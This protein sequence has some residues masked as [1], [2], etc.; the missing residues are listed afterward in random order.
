[1]HH[2]PE[3]LAP[4]GDTDA[5]LAAIAAGAD[6]IFLGLKHFSARMKAENFSIISLANIIALAH[7]HQCKVYVAFNTLIKPSDIPSVLHMLSRIRHAAHPDALIIQD[8]GLIPIIQDMHFPGEIHLSTL[9]NVTHTTSLEEARHI[10][11]HRVVLPR[12]ILLSEL[13]AINTTCPKGLHL[14]IFVHGALCY[15]VS[16]RCYWSSYLGGKSGLRGRCVQPCRRVYSQGKNSARFFSSLDLSLESLVQTLLPLTAIKSWKIEGRKKSPHYV[17][18]T[19][20]AYRIL[21]DNPNDAT[22]VAEAKKLL[23]YAISRTTIALPKQ[24]KEITPV[25]LTLRTNT[26]ICVGEVLAQQSL[27]DK[28]FSEEQ[29]AVLISYLQQNA[30]SA[31]I[32]KKQRLET[33]Q[34]YLLQVFSESKQLPSKHTQKSTHPKKTQSTATIPHILLLE[35]P[36]FPGDKIRIGYEDEA[37]HCSVRINKHYAQ[38]SAFLLHL[39][40]Q[41]PAKASVFAYLIDR[42][43]AIPK[44]I[45]QSLTQELAS[46]SIH[47]PPS[48]HYEY[49]FPKAHKTRSTPRMYTV[50]SSIPKGRTNKVHGLSLWISQKTVRAISRTVVPKVCWWLPPVVWEKEE[51]TLR[52]MVHTL[53]RRGARHFVC[54]EFFQYA[55]LPEKAEKILGPFCNAANI[56]TLSFAK[57]VGYTKAIVSTELS[58][59]DYSLI[60]KQSPIPLGIVTRGFY[61]IGITR[62]TPVGFNQKHVFTSTQKESFWVRKYGANYWY[63]P[64]WELDLSQKEQE[65][66]SFGYTF[67]VHIQEFPSQEYTTTRKTSTFNWDLQLL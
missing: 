59:E 58:K 26:G 8:V 65:L 7:R 44:K 54:N 19:T 1:M 17:Y 2:R 46:L 21:R 31:T 36:L 41:I 29:Y 63:Y 28:K 50:Q 62:F 32:S 34:K 12:E 61:P 66:Q 57:S 14:E 11:V 15:M 60:A 42:K 45:L 37:W 13:D 10:G 39:A 33:V 5:A 43:T 27:H 56:A 3:I 4:A 49:L 20:K 48:P 40:K 35:E 22:A 47:S 30:N 51:D 18:H 9:A 53:I 6:A 24:Y 55:L 23:Q 16:G 38:G 52:S 64:T 25:N 67:F